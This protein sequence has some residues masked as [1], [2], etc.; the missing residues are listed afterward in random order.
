MAAGGWVLLM[1]F[2]GG[3]WVFL[4]TSILKQS[5]MAENLDL[6]KPVIEI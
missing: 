4:R 2:F 6:F 3:F 5:M 1:G